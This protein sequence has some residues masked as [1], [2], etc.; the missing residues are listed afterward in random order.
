MGLRETI[1]ADTKTIL[2]DDVMGFGWA[3]SVTDPDGT[4]R[5]FIGYSTDIGQVIDPDTGVV[6]SGRVASVVL[7]LKSLKD[8]EL[9]IPE[10]ISD[11]AK[12][13]WLIR[14]DDINGTSHLFKI[15]ETNPDRAMGIVVCLLELYEEC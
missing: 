2:E 6:L 15:S 1:A 12:K 11:S 5:P 10:G 3:I 9:E 8:V 4:S 14:F 13:P 7:N